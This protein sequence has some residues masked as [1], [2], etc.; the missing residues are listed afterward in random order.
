MSSNG[1]KHITTCMLLKKDG[2]PCNQQF[3]DNPINVQIIGRPDSH[4]Q[5]F[6]SGLMQHVQ[7]KHPQD[8]MQMQG[9]WMSFLGYLILR[10]FESEDE[11]LVK[12]RDEFAAY[13]RYVCAVPVSDEWLQGLVEVLAAEYKAKGE[14]PILQ[15][16]MKLRDSLTRV[17]EMKDKLPAEK[18]LI[19]PV[20]R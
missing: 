8:W 16:F 2:T 4:V 18:S 14:A 19:V 20:G 5:K 9:S 17:A 15:A 1:L 11:N 12:S 13:M 6:I 7:K 3:A 10:G